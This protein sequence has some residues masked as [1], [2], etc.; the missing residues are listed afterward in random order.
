MSDPFELLALS[1]ACPAESDV[2]PATH[3]DMQIV[4]GQ[5]NVSVSIPR[6]AEQTAKASVLYATKE[7]Y[8][9]SCELLG[10]WLSQPA[11]DESEKQ[12]W[13]RSS[14]N[15]KFE[16]VMHRDCMRLMERAA[17]CPYSPDSKVTL[18]TSMV[19]CLR[20]AHESIFDRGLTSK[21]S[22]D[23]SQGYGGVQRGYEALE[24][25]EQRGLLVDPAF[26]GAEAVVVLL[27]LIPVRFS[28]RTKRGDEVSREIRIDAALWNFEYESREPSRGKRFERNWAINIRGVKFVRG[29]LCDMAKRFIDAEQDDRERN[30]LPTMNPPAKIEF[31]Q[32]MSD[33]EIK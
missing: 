2:F 11:S 25:L 29:L 3:S 5:S 21:T 15:S 18:P 24:K 12:W 27:G 14:G 26:G 33:D 22:R 32:L 16:E 13:I 6:K 28:N 1:L 10:Q 23:A 7:T 20:L 9:M 31:R 4:V 19:E 17:V 30:Q 8:L